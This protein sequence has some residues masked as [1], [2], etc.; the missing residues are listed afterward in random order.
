MPSRS[1]PGADLSPMAGS[2]TLLVDWPTFRRRHVRVGARGCDSRRSYRCRSSRHRI[3]DRWQP[4]RT[5]GVPDVVRCGRDGRFVS[6]ELASCP[7]NRAVHGFAVLNASVEIL[8]TRGRLTHLP[9][10]GTR[11]PPLARMVG[12]QIVVGTTLEPGVDRRRCSSGPLLRPAGLHPECP[13][14][15]APDA[16]DEPAP[17]WHSGSVSRLEIDRHARVGVGV[18]ACA[19]SRH[20]GASRLVTCLGGQG[21]VVHRCLADG[22]FEDGHEPAIADT[23]DQ[24]R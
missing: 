3:A 14:L 6:G 18:H 13:R 5:S 20:G 2:G 19:G 12:G 8:L 1:R 17:G 22:A 16:R 15:D 21:E 10:R 23:H 9:G 4:R 7:A 11:D 24:A